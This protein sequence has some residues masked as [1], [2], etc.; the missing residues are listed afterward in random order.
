MLPELRKDLIIMKK[1]SGNH[2][3]LVDRQIIEAGLSN[4]ATKTSIANTIGKDK[5]TVGKEIKLRRVISFKSTLPRECTNY[6]HC[7]FKRACRSTC[8]DYKEFKC[9]RRDRSP[10]ACNGCSNYPKCRFT[11]YR[12]SA[13]TADSDYRSTLVECRQGFNIDLCTLKQ[14]G[15]IITPLLKQGQ[16]IEH[17]LINHPEIALSHQTLYTYLESNIFKTL[18]FDIGVIDLRRKVSRKLPKSKKIL[19]KPRND[20]TYLKGRLYKDYQEYI[21]QE[22]NASLVELDT[23]YNNISKGPYIQTF[24]FVRYSF[25]FAILHQEKTAEAMNDG[26]L[27]LKKILGDALFHQEVQVL[28]TDRGSEFVKLPQ[29]EVDESQVRHF[30]A[31]YCDPMASSQKPHI[32]NKH[33]LLRYILPKE[34]SLESLGL[35][36]QQDLNLVLAHINSSPSVKLNGKSPLEFMR[37]LCPEMAKK[38]SQYGITQIPKDDVTLRPTLL[39]NK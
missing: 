15:R 24:L 27:L 25:L 21:T 32:E 38:F 9:T 17:I 37:F 12:Y 34:V 20:R 14:I 10:G 18:G 33:E 11:K 3:T 4:G 22:P 19:Y 1:F 2:L 7:K 30:R 35:H 36:S 23:V 28:L 31:Y 29:I 6:A 39:K 16:S 8:P 5:S 13:N 26:I